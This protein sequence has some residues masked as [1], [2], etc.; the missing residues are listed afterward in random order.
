MELTDILYEKTKGIA[1]ITINRPNV[2]N[3]FRARTIEELI[4]SF[5]DAWDD[6]RIGA[7]ILTGAGEKAFCTGGDQKEKGNEGGY[8]S[9]GGLGGGIGLEIENLHQTIRNIPKPVI[10]AVNGYA[11]GGGHVLHVICDLTIAASTAKFGQSGPK[12]GSY[13]A[14]FGSAYLARIVGEKKAREIWYLC[15]QYT[16]E[17]C[18]EMGLVNKIVPPEKLQEAAEEWAEKILQKSPTAIKMLKYSFNADSANIQGISQL[19]MGS[20]ALFYNSPESEEGKNAFIEK[21]PVDFSQFRK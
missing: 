10:A 12:V 3:A 17:E 21:R 9:S 4:W 8:D 19:S 11:I 14:G 6:N 16:A 15:E 2:Y 1:K 13:D 5:R 18:K 20:L 7:V